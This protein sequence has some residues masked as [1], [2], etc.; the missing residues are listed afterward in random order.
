MKVKVAFL[1]LIFMFAASS[2]HAVGPVDVELEA[3]AWFTG[4]SGDVRDGVVDID[5]E[6]DLGVGDETTF[7]I[8]GRLDVAFLGNI[9][10]GYTPLEYDGTGRVSGDFGGITVGTDVK[11]ELDVDTYD[12][13]W[14]FTLLDLTGVDLEL[15]LNVKYAEGTVSV[16]EIATAIKE[17]ADLGFPIPMLK[18]V[19]RVSVPMVTAELDAMGL[20]I[21]SYHAYDFM[22]Q[23]KIT[24]LPFVYLAGGY[25][26]MDIYLKDDPEK[27]ALAFQGPFVA[28]GVEF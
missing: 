8:R 19:A 26:Y 28:A 11:T 18:A 24:P 5:V 1:L 21:G 10:L 16:T 20:T 25:R 3:G 7:F 4:V 22:A 9:Y 23:V 27:L 6:D 2:A 17:E 15:G 14:T 13:G 12:L